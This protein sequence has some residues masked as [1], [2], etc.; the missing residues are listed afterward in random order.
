MVRVTLFL[1]IFLL[2]GVCSCRDHES[3]IRDRNEYYPSGKIKR[4]GHFLNDSIPVDTVQSF[5]ENGKIQS[6]GVYDSTGKLNGVSYIYHEN[7]TIKQQLNYVQGLLDGA[8]VDYDSNGSVYAKGYYYQDRMVGDYYLMKNDKVFLNAFYD[9]K[10]RKINH[11]EYDSIGN[12][13][14]NFRQKIYLDS[15][16][17]QMDSG[18]HYSYR[19]LLIISNPLRSKNEI[20]ISYIGPANNILAVESVYPNDAPY[21][22]LNKRFKSDLASIKIF[23]SQ[24]DSILQKSTTQTSVT[25]I[26]YSLK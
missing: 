17:V 3:P 20:S 26:D 11:I 8:L 9:F 12:I 23:G 19:I 16:S 18:N 24:Y 14:G 22:I 13:N 7:G 10:G 4:R 1:G 21:V 2:I 25:N 15:I 5:Y 6:I